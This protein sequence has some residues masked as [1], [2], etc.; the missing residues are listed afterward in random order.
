MPATE[1]LTIEILGDSSGLSQSLDDALAKVESLQSATDGASTAAAGIGG[2]LATISSAMQPLQ[3]IGQQLT[4]I[5]QQAQALGQQ[6]ITL[7][8]QPA[9]SAL[10]MLLSAIQAVAAQLSA[11]SLPGVGPIRGP[12]GTGG[13]GGGSGSGGGSGGTSPRSSSPQSTSGGNYAASG[14]HAAQYSPA[15]PR[16]NS[17]SPGATR[18][19][20]PSE[21]GMT[22]SHRASPLRQPIS[23]QSPAQRVIADSAHQPMRD[24][25]AASRTASRESSA[26]D[27]R[28]IP[29]PSGAF[30]S[31]LTSI[32]RSIPQDHSSSTVNHF[33][34][35]TIEVR[36]T[37]DVNTLMRD[38]RLQGLSTRHRQG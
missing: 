3:Q 29:R 17:S 11:L 35:I 33:G 25:T 12:G 4:R 27:S 1:S 9:L 30:S 19:G 2:K 13:G 26:T 38:L 7:N 21:N 6:P 20:S 10:Q 16:W 23:I 8:V 24:F 18:A 34:G 15:P 14:Q 5:T 28:G 32:D 36:E 37:A 22:T 31:S